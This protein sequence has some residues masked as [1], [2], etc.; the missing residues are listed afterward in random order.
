[1]QRLLRWSSFH[2]LLIVMAAF[3]VLSFKSMATNAFTMNTSHQRVAAA[4]IIKH[5]SKNLSTELH[6]SNSNNFLENWKNFFEP[7]GKRGNKNTSDDD[8]DDEIPA[9]QYRIASISVKSMKPGALRLFLMFYL[10][11][12]QNTP[13]ANSWRAHQPTASKSAKS[14]TA[15]ENN[16]EQ[17]Q[18]QE[19][20]VEFLYHD[21][22]ALLSVTMSE[23]D[24]RISIDR[25]G[26]KPST[27]YMM[28][29][30]TIVQGIL[31]ELEQ[32]TTDPQVTPEN[33]LLIVQPANAID[34]A[35]DAL[36]FG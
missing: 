24:K 29:E 21:H 13:E 6:M 15:E 30:S 32:M 5:G 36:A 14:L 4:T 34:A 10:L 26:S 19:H 35:R 1:M 12:M 18:Q 9:G 31:N 11:G 16:G 17:E 2:C 7:G 22:S 3:A 20:V 27:A 8:D 33:R 25:V 28:H 23:Q